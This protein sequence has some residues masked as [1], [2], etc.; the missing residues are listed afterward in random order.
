MI[1]SSMI[2]LRKLLDRYPTSEPNSF[3]LKNLFLVS[4]K[5]LGD[6]LEDIRGS[7]SGGNMLGPSY[8]VKSIHSKKKDWNI[9]LIEIIILISNPINRITFL[10]NTRHLSHTSK[11]IYSLIIKRKNVNGEWIDDKIESWVANNDSI[12]DEERKFLV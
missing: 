8:G 3:W 11:G 9:N 2:E 6:S 5:Q 7:A 4:L 10:R 1:P 12:D